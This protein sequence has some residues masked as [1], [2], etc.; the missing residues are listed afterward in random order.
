MAG[1]AAT[2]LPPVIPDD[3][4]TRMA[5]D[6]WFAVSEGPAGTHGLG[7]AGRHA[8]FSDQPEP[9]YDGKC[10][11]AGIALEQP[12]LDRGCLYPW[13]YL[14]GD[15]PAAERRYYEAAFL[16]GDVRSAVFTTSRGNDTIRRQATIYR[17]A[18]LPGWAIAVASPYRPADGPP[19]TRAPVA[20]HSFDAY[21][22]ND[23]RILHCAIPK[24]GA[25][26]THDH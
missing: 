25:T 8:R 7:V 17:L 21:D 4:W 13:G 2:P 16:R 9:V 6:V 19:V 5:D 12:S 22:A 18:S 1:A 11:W 20:R 15:G 23:K 3:T 14:A 24:P 10:A 26:P